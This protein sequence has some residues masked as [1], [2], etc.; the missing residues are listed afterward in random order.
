MVVLALVA[1]I[2]L[3]L[4][5]GES[6]FA[7]RCH[8][9]TIAAASSKHFVHQITVFISLILL[10]HLMLHLLVLVQLE[11]RWLGRTS[12]DRRPLMVNY[13]SNYFNDTVQAALN[14]MIMLITYC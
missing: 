1:L 8:T 10:L 14:K 5:L 11:W 2:Q 9:A 4:V 3:V 12:L 6:T 7:S 13:P